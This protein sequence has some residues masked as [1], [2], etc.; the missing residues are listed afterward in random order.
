M[1]VI[2]ERIL[3]DDSARRRFLR[4]AWAAANHAIQTLPRSSIRAEA[5][6]IAFT[7]TWDGQQRSARVSAP[8]TKEGSGE[9]ISLFTFRHRSIPLP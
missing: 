1:K 9:C 6:G 5:A 2:S 4:E 8:L 3:G 7:R